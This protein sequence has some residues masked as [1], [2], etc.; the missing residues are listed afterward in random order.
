ML[1]LKLCAAPA[2]HTRSSTAAINIFFIISKY[3]IGFI[4]ELCYDLRAKL[5]R[6]FRNEKYFAVFFDV[7]TFS[8]DFIRPFLAKADIK[9]AWSALLA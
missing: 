9:Q 2:I 6:K 4:A 3:L 7:S 5:V 8:L 1:A